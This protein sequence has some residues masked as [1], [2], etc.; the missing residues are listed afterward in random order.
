MKYRLKGR[1]KRK[2]E[3]NYTQ[4]VGCQEINY[5]LTVCARIYL[6]RDLIDHGGFITSTM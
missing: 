6:C 5:F 3:E 2:T 1:K 4:K